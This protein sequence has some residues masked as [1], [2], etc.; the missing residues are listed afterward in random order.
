MTVILQPKNK[1]QNRYDKQIS[2]LH[3]ALRHCIDLLRW[4]ERQA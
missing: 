4:R 3:D 1:D 2:N